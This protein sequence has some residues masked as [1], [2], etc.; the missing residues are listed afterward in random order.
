[1]WFSRIRCLQIDWLQPALLASC[2]ISC[3]MLAVLFVNSVSL[4]T[5]GDSVAV[6]TS[7]CASLATDIRR[8]SMDRSSA[9]R[10]TVRP[11]MNTETALTVS[12]SNV[13]MLLG[14]Q[15]RC[16]WLVNLGVFGTF[17]LQNWRTSLGHKFA[18]ENICWLMN[19]GIF[20][21]SSN[22]KEVDN[23]ILS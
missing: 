23:Q 15:P 10:L 1:M 21:L 19:V 9:S 3:S 8:G 22:A 4:C 7:A 11:K 12:P 17:A 20:H 14:D 13:C 2:P 5:A 16:P 6:A 18:T